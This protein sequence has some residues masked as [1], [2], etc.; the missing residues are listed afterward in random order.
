MKSIDIY[1]IKETLKRFMKEQD[2][3][4]EV[5]R[6]ILREVLDE[7]Q[8]EALAEIKKEIEEGDNGLISKE[9]KNDNR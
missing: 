5:K 8:A 4:A 9:E 7:V 1:S 6:M 2:I 3:P